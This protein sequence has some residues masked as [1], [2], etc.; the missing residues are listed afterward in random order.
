M[1][2]STYR[3]M[4]VDSIM[5]RFS[6]SVFISLGIEERN[7]LCRDLAHFCLQNIMPSVAQL[8]FGRDRENKI[9]LWIDQLRARGHDLWR[10]DFDEDYE[11]FGCD[12]AKK[13]S[14]GLMIELNFPD[15]VDIYWRDEK[16][17]LSGSQE[18]E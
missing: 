17:Q 15:K 6:W 14:F 11:L 18:A 8:P 10:W 3:Y 1:G 5:E 12:Y 4:E 2:S 7:K 9:F 13:G 16:D